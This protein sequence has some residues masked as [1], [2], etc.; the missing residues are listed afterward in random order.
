[1]HD[2]TYSTL[3]DFVSG[4]NNASN[5]LVNTLQTSLDSFNDTSP[6]RL[7]LDTIGPQQ[8][9]DRLYGLARLAKSLTFRE[10]KRLERKDHDQ[11]TKR[12]KSNAAPTVNDVKKEEGNRTDQP[13]QDSRNVLTL[14]GNAQGHKQLFS[15]VQKPSP[16][17]RKA[18][19]TDDGSRE[20][21]EVGLPNG[22]SSTRV[23]YT[24]TAA[25][26]NP[27]TFQDLFAPPSSLPQIRPP[28][29]QKAPFDKDAP[30]TWSRTPASDQTSRSAGYLN[31][32]LGTG[33]WLGYS[34]LTMPDEPSSPQAKRRQRD[35][36]LSMST[37]GESIQQ[38]SSGPTSAQKQAHE[39]ALF[40]SAFSSFA[41]TRDNTAALVPEETKNHLWWQRYGADFFDDAFGYH[42]S[43]VG[44]DD[45][46]SLK[47]QQG[48][49]KQEDAE[50]EEAVENY[51]PDFEIREPEGEKILS[52]VSE[53]LEQLYS[54]QRIRMSSLPT[55]GRPSLSYSASPDSAHA[56]TTPTAAE[57]ETYKALKAQL[58][59]TISTL[60]PFL[61]S[62]LNGEQL[63]GLSITQSMPMTAP[64]HRGVMEED[65]A[66]RM[67]K[68]QAFQAAVGAA[69]GPG[70]NAAST[71]VNNAA[72][73][74]A[75]QPPQTARPA[76]PPNAR[77]G[78]TFAR[79]HLSNWQ[80]PQNQ[81]MTIQRPQYASGQGFNQPRPGMLGG[82]Q[83]PD[84]SQSAP[85]PRPTQLN[86]GYHTPQ[87]GYN[88]RPPQGYGS[89][90]QPQAG[91]PPRLG[92]MSQPR[93]PPGQQ[94]QHG[95]Q[96]YQQQSQPPQ[97]PQQNGY[98]PQQ[99]QQQ[100][101]YSQTHSQ[102]GQSASPQPPQP[103]G[104]PNGVSRP[105]TPS[106]P[107]GGGQQQGQQ[108]FVPA[109][110]KATAP[111]QNHRDV[112]HTPQPPQKMEAT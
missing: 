109:Q 47:R 68:Q 83:R 55:P 6:W 41:P 71:P 34:G 5:H 12:G 95:Q 111:Q 7:L 18:D 100:Q 4:I 65:Q 103:V 15:S 104:A 24:D 106:T 28:K 8:F 49:L 59:L 89:A 110:G 101:R 48:Q 60:P 19:S 62:K 77:G 32:K 92:Q 20:L 52:E 50:F 57:L 40:R 99:Q 90:H 22:I 94:M 81:N 91:S 74:R 11:K 45:F 51:D 37:G 82:L 3:H 10:I 63:E 69:R 31:E 56:A 58:A 87:P 33:R 27:S 79:Q 29:P 43:T 39:D 13:D 93:Y 25:R 9:A 105:Q 35:R 1:M 73:A 70:Q 46:D 88:Q 23:Y 75:P 44:D 84:Y 112:S 21:S 102:L 42:E 108:G 107:L 38:A 2:G 30:L 53:M 72:P 26:R 64:N 14:Y 78:S 85:R 36:A 76:M 61:V 67:A 16:R 17:D 54:F 96:Q 80:T 66:S 98:Q 97:Y 86:G